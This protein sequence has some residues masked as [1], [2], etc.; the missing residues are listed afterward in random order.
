MLQ[1]KQ[2]QKRKP[3][4]S[5]KDKSDP[6]D[7]FLFF[8]I[9]VFFLSELLSMNQDSQEN[10]CIVLVVTFANFTV[11]TKNEVHIL[12]VFF[13]YTVHGLKDKSENYC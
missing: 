7:V 3:R 9:D 12:H 13:S 8:Y 5:N 2:Q 1:F 11:C 4:K 10:I 6:L